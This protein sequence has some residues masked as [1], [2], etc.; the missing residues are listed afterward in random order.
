VFEDAFILIPP[1]TGK[2]KYPYSGAK[3]AFNVC[4]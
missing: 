3:E 2:V 4:R 1:S